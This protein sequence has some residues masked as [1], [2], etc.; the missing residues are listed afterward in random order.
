MKWS[1]C[2]IARDNEGTIGQT[3]ASVQSFI[4]EIIVVDTGSL[5]GTKRVAESYGA[6]TYDFEW[7]DD[8]A[9]ARNFSFSKATGDWIMWL[10]TGDTVP[11]ESARAFQQLKR[12]AAVNDPNDPLEGF[13][14]RINR[15][16]TDEGEVLSWYLIPRLVRRSANPVWIEPVHEIV[17]TDNDTMQVFRDAW[18]D[19]PVALN[20]PGS[21]RNLRILERLEAG[22]RD[23]AWL[24]FHIA[25]E[26]FVHKDWRP[27]IDYY[28][29]MLKSGEFTYRRYIALTNIHLCHTELGEPGKGIDYLFQAIYFNPSRAEA[30]IT[31]GDWFFDND[32]WEFARP[33]YQ[34]VLGLVIP[35]DGSWANPNAYGHYPHGKLAFCHYGAGRTK[36]ALAEFREALRLAPEIHREPYRRV[37]KQIQHER[38]G[39]P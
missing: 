15:H 30:F 31:I 5:D 8:F 16:I 23:D 2:I 39:K 34:A 33:F 35:S 29:R 21:N 32:Q 14:V 10:D 4:D 13:V 24:W 38:K 17:H 37:I 9:A 22:G 28:L 3:L 19:D 18:V 6:K 11:P 1:L 12:S 20:N 25:S 7:V 27:A 36:E 26:H